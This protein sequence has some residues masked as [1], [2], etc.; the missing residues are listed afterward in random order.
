MIISASKNN[1]PTLD[2]GVYPL[3]S[4]F[5]QV[6][7]QVCHTDLLLAAYIDASE[8]SNIRFHFSVVLVISK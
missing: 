1:V 2:L 4:Q 8:Q 3:P 7:F 6:G 5:V